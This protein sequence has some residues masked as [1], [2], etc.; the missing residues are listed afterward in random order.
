MG[1]HTTGRERVGVGLTRPRGCGGSHTTGR[2]WVGPAPQTNTILLGG[3]GC[4]AWEFDSKGVDWLGLTYHRW[5]V[6]SNTKL[7]VVKNRYR[8]RPDNPTT[9][10]SPTSRPHW[11]ASQRSRRLRVNEKA[12]SGKSGQTS[13]PPCVLNFVFGS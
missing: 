3:K 1:S 5:L 2:E 13:R 4:G 7:S 9:R 8:S 11:P 10:G 12:I 6:L